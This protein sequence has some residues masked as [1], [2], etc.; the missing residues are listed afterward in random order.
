MSKP[1]A[2]FEESKHYGGVASVKFYPNAHFYSVTDPEWVNPKDPTNP[3]GSVKFTPLVN[4][5]IGGATSITG[6]MAKG[7]G[8]MLY[9]LYEGIKFLRNYFGSTTVADFV[10][11]PET[12]ND[13]LKLVAGAHVKKSDRGKSVGTDSHAWVQLYLEAHRDAAK[14]GKP[15]VAPPIADT[16]EIAVVLRRNYLQVINDIK[17]KTF[18]QYASIPKLILKS[19][20]V[21]EAIWIEAEMIRKSTSAAKAWFEMHDIV[22]HGVEDTIY[23]RQLLSAGKYDA[24]LGVLCTKKCNWCYRNGD[25]S[26]PEE[27][28][29]GR[30]VTDFKST[31]AS[32]Y[33]PKG[34][35]S[36]YLAQ[37]GVYDIGITEEHPEIVFDGHLILNGSKNEE[38]EAKDGTKLPVF[39]THFSFNREA[40]CAWARCAAE[41]KEHMYRGEKEIEASA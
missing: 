36:E 22:V 9:P 31:N 27:D 6:V 25:L 40:N 24:D 29:D 13:L 15:F 39:S 16:E 5:R 8:L 18:E 20:A 26:K 21:E 12:I 38:K 35:Y 41:L 10:D 37:C 4:K 7:Q 28:F 11:N 14:A 19:I 3:N 30:Y 32:T 2:E 33:S 1:A 34:I 17:P 23:S